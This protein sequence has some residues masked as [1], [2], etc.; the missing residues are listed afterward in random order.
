MPLAMQRIE[1]QLPPQNNEA[2][3]SVLG[4][5]LLQPAALIS[6]MEFI[7]TNDFYRRSHQLIFQAM[8]DLNERN[9][10]VDIVTVADRLEN[11]KQLEDVGGSAYLAELSTIVPTDRKSVV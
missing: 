6:A 1:D 5:I 3:Q 8:I 9:E 7:Q 2:E 11:N 4:S 10:E